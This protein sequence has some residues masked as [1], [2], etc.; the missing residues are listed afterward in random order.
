MCVADEMKCRSQW[1]SV[2]DVDIWW[3]F[4]RNLPTDQTSTRCQQ[5]TWQLSSD[6]T[7]CGR[8]ETARK[9][10]VFSEVMMLLDWTSAI[11]IV[12]YV[13]PRCLLTFAKHDVSDSEFIPGRP[14]MNSLVS[15]FSL[16]FQWFHNCHNVL[17]CILQIQFVQKSENFKLLK[18]S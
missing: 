3:G 14:G 9:C 1:E 7:Y 4:Y 12:H 15:D 16:K 8:M 10:C 11:F 5:A 18:N 2:C 17:R 13:L 6:Q